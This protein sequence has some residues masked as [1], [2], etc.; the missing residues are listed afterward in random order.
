MHHASW[1]LKVKRAQYHMVEIRRAVRDYS[2]M[3]PYEV[4]RIRQKQRYRN[5]WRYKLVFT[6]QP[7]AMI[8]VM[9]GDFVHNL[10]SALDHAV[11]ACSVPRFQKRA[12]FPIAYKNIWARDASGDYLIRDDEG[13]ESFARAIEG[14]TSEARKVILRA[15]PYMAGS[16]GEHA[17]R[18]I[19]GVLSRLENADKHRQLIIISNILQAPYLDFII[20]GKSIQ[21]PRQST[22]REFLHADTVIINFT[23]D[24]DLDESEVQ[25]ECRG[26]AV[27]SIKVTGIRGNEPLWDYAL[28]D[29]LL[30]ALRYVR[31]LLRQLEPF[32]RQ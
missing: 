19:I 1:W 9:L 17:D 2:A 27:V 8:A 32:V 20:G 13:R 5:R 11:V 6:E 25:V 18:D 14:L 15:Q 10:R 23:S 12:S 30:G 3:N 21:G 26:T 29:T 28:A 16:G 4:V 7:N 31:G 22:K 24:S